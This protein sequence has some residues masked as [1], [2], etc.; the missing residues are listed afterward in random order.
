MNP[1]P[2]A[3]ADL[4][5]GRLRNNPQFKELGDQLRQDLRGI[6]GAATG[7]LLER[8]LDTLADRLH[9]RTARLRERLSEAVP[10]GRDL[11]YGEKEPA[12]DERD[13]EEPDAEEPDAGEWAGDGPDAGERAAGE[14]DDAERYVDEPHGEEPDDVERDA[15]EPVLLV[16]EYYPKG[17]FEKTGNLWRA[18]GRRGEIRDGEVVHGHEPRAEG[19]PGA[20]K[21]TEEPDETEETRDT[22]EPEEIDDEYRDE[23]A[24][25]RSRR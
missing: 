7:A 22:E 2:R 9:D 18:Q 14:P 20:Q 23:Y 24:D 25:A 17:L 21:E 8:Q 15:E 3:L 12:D 4:V 19:E 16:I 5:S 11:G 10:E 13:A 6:G 1:G